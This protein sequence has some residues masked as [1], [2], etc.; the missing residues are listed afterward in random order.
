V[1][2]GS[3]TFSQVRSSASGVIFYLVSKLC[4]RNVG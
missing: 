3:A 1:P 2:S 4:G